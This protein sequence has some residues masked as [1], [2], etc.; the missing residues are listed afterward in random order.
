MLRI[1]RLFSIKSFLTIRLV[2][3]T[4]RSSAPAS[5]TRRDPQNKSL[6]TA[7]LHWAIIHISS[8]V[9]RYIVPITHQIIPSPF[10]IEMI[11]LV[12]V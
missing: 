4:L 12:N 7:S 1:L 2:T 6:P 11:L 3:E 9:E 8:A 5:N 10:R